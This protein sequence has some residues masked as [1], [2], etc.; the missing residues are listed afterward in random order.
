[1]VDFILCEKNRKTTF[2]THIKYAKKANGLITISIRH[3]NLI[4]HMQHLRYIS[5]HSRLVTL[6][7]LS[8]SLYFTSLSRYLTN[9][10][11]NSSFEFIS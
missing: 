4:A 7:S 10:K 11:V 3:K 9:I 8:L 5:N 2:N 6:L 1:M